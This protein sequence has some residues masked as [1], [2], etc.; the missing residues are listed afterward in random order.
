MTRATWA[1]LVPILVG[2][3]VADVG[4]QAPK[5]VPAGRTVAAPAGPRPARFE[6]SVGGWWMSGYDLGDRDAVLTANRVPTGDDF[7]LFTTS[8]EVSPAAALDVRFGVLASQS[9]TVEAAAVT[10]RP[11]LQTSIAGDFEQG[12]PEV[13]VETFD[14]VAFEG[15]ALWHPRQWAFA[16]GK[17]R[18]FVAGGLGY[19]EQLGDN[20]VRLENG[21]VYHVGG[22]LK[23]LFG[24]PPTT[25]RRGVGLRID[26]R[27]SW[28]SGGVDVDETVRTF[29]GFGG[30][31]F[32]RF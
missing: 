11:E 10:S 7:V 18:P 14:Q 12:S 4:A 2:C 29:A 22:G 28:R 9:F 23:W 27:M 31:V 5:P 24:A 30:A 16:S 8:S 26:A 25:R 15:Q 3:A 1:V 13:A 32:Y 17:A 6:V 21:W 19:L 20:R